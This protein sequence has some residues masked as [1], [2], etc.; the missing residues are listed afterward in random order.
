MTKQVWTVRSLSE[1]TQVPLFSSQFYKIRCMWSMWSL[2]V[3]MLQTVIR[4][5][6]KA[7]D[8]RSFTP[9]RTWICRFL[10]TILPYK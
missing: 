9:Y 6:T 5:L 1:Y 2:A 8:S 7:S 3:R 10:S 4:H